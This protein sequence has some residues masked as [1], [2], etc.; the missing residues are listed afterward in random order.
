M[1]SLLS[2][3][4][5]KMILIFVFKKIS[6]NEGHPTYFVKGKTIIIIIINYFAVRGYRH[7]NKWY[8]L[9]SK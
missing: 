5:M 4:L 7:H 1:K 3:Y 6:L 9:P 2:K 8:I